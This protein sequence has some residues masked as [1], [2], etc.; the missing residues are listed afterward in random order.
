LPLALIVDRLSFAQIGD[1]IGALI[2]ALIGKLDDR[3][4]GE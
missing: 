4:R 3:A 1:L 2:G